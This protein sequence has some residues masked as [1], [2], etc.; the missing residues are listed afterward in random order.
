MLLEVFQDTLLTRR[1]L[2]FGACANSG[3]PYWDSYCVTKVVDQFI[4]V[5]AYVPG[6]PP[7]RAFRGG[8]RLLAG[9][10]GTR[11]AGR[12]AAAVLAAVIG[13]CSPP[14][15]QLMIF[16]SM[17]RTVIAATAATPRRGL[18][19]YR[20]AMPPAMSKMMR[21]FAVRKSSP[22][23]RGSS[24]FGGRTG[25]MVVAAFSVRVWS[26]GGSLVGQGAAVFLYG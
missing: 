11:A 10:P 5:G 9:W 2:S 7:L 26:L 23:R 3:G 6:C 1:V 14:Q 17:A 15:I 19:T 16:Q 12:A 13:P 8:A 4:P 20:S 24:S 21:D 25:S 22:G 18:F